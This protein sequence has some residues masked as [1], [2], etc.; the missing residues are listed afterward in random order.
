MNTPNLQT[1]ENVEVQLA[2]VIPT[3]IPGQEMPITLCGEKQDGIRVTWE[4][5]NVMIQQLGGAEF[6][7]EFL[8]DNDT[9]QKLADFY[10]R[11]GSLPINTE[12]SIISFFRKIMIYDTAIEEVQQVQESMKN[13]MAEVQVQEKKK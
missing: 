5:I 12:K 11:H 2:K 3:K 4:Y 1:P 7:I 9:F 8:N 10:E 13:T 6:F